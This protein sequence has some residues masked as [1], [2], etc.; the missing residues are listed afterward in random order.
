MTTK[1]TFTVGDYVVLESKGVFQIEAL[2][3]IELAGSSQE[4]FVLKKEFNK[5]IHKNFISV[6]QAPK[7]LRPVCK[8]MSL[9][10]LLK[11]AQEHSFDMPERKTNAFKKIQF[12]DEYVKNDGFEGLLKAYWGATLDLSLLGREEK[13]LISYKEKLEIALIEEM[14]CAYGLSLDE[15]KNL[16]LK[17]TVKICA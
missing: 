7:K 17:T 9:E 3:D 14:S 11:W 12:F 8:N 15:A 6:V 16:L 13:R 10:V 4:C 5:A 1:D 2:E